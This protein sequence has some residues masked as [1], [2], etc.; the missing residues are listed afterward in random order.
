[1]CSNDSFGFGMIMCLNSSVQRNIDS[2][3]IEY[4]LVRDEHFHYFLLT[5]ICSN[6]IRISTFSEG[7]KNH[8][9]CVRQCSHM[10]SV[11]GSL[12]RILWI[13]VKDISKLLNSFL[14]NVHSYVH[15]RVFTFFT[16]LGMQM[17]HGRAVTL[18]NS[19]TLSFSNNMHSLLIALKQRPSFKLR[20]IL[21]GSLSL[22]WSFWKYYLLRNFLFYDLKFRWL[23]YFLVESC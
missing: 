8:S 17:T 9:N 3:D 12:L 21:T 13:H 4:F 15:R 18:D 14:V 7:Y 19:I 20:W 1:M 10:D 5:K 11:Q 6:S 2:I 16:A 22:L 23:M